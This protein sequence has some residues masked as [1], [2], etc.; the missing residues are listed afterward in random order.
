MDVSIQELERLLVDSAQAFEDHDSHSGSISKKRSLAQL[1]SRKEK[2]EKDN[3][4]RG[5]GEHS[6]FGIF[7]RKSLFFASSFVSIL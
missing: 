3:D 1:R 5:K 7:H 2:E 4:Q 6:I